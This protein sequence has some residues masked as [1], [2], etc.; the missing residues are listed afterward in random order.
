[1]NNKRKKIE[2]KSKNIKKNKNM[3]KK[4]TKVQFYKANI[5]KTVHNK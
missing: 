4:S 2:M 5:K 1:M 3:N